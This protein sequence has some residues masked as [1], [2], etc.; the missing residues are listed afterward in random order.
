[1]N[2]RS[3]N[4]FAYLYNHSITLSCHIDHSGLS[5]MHHLV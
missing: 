1:M 3:T 4:L 5:Q 2:Y